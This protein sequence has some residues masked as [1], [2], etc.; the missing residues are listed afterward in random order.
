MEITAFALAQRYVGIRELSAQGKD[1]PLISWWMSLCGLALDTPDEIPWCSGYPNGIAW[2]LRLP[3]SKS[4]AARSWLGVGTPVSLAEAAVGWDVVI[5]TRGAGAQPGP[6]V[7]HAPGHVGFF[8]GW[9][10]GDGWVLVLGGN[11]SNGVTIQAFDP[12]RIL[13]MRRLL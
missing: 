11:Q 3:R 2:E 10:D 12:A 8:A 13:G 9:R 5:L 7:L 1:H 6:D 4:A